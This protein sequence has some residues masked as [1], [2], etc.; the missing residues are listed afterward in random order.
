LR[1]S[2]SFTEKVCE[3]LPERKGFCE[4]QRKVQGQHNLPRQVEGKVKGEAV[5]AIP[6]L[7]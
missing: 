7:N 2:L 1:P 5:K 6:A 3:F 4:V